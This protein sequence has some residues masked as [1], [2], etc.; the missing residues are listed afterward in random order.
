[1]FLVNRLGG[2]HLE[3]GIWLEGQ[4]SHLPDRNVK[5]VFSQVWRL[6]YVD[7][8]DFNFVFL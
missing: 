6:A 5:M 4:S 3:W 1:M 2:S 7:E 8:F